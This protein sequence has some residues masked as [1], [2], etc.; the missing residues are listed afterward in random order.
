M[1]TAGTESKSFS[2]KELP[3]GTGQI[4]IRNGVL[5]VP[6]WKD[7]KLHLFIIK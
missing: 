6:G 5:A 4:S 3:A 2:C 7:E 1:C